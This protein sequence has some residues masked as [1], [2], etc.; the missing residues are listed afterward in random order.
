MLVYTRYL[1][2]SEEGRMPNYEKYASPTDL[3]GPTGPTSIVGPSGPM[4]FVGL[5]SNV[6]RCWLAM[7]LLAGFLSWVLACRT[8]ERKNE[9]QILKKQ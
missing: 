3:V 2:L 5:L 9:I 8:I 6:R 4:S 1:F 7:P